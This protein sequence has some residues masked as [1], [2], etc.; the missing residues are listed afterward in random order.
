MYT[1]CVCAVGSWG[2]VDSSDPLTLTEEVDSHY[3][4]RCWCPISNKR[5]SHTHSLIKECLTCLHTSETAVT[6]SCNCNNRSAWVTPVIQKATSLNK[7]PHG[8]RIVVFIL[9]MFILKEIYIIMGNSIWPFHFL[10]DNNNTCIENQRMM[11]NSK[12]ILSKWHLEIIRSITSFNRY[13]VDMKVIGL[14]MLDW[15]QK[16]P[17]CAK[18]NKSSKSKSKDLFVRV[19]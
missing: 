18:M 12:S 4:D 16:G 15:C 17:K 2:Q 9:N 19:H 10:Q 6:W 5:E 3:M 8:T 1:R 11:E 7:R 14:L 13:I